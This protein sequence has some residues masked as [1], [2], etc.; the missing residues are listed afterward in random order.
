MTQ[1]EAR[2]I[3]GK[4]FIA[5][6][7]VA[8]ILSVSI[9]RKARYALQHIPYSDGTLQTCKKSHILFP[10]VPEDNSG[11]LITIASIRE[12]FGV[13]F[14][15][16]PCFSYVDYWYIDENFASKKT[17]SLR[18]Y[19]I[20]KSILP[21]SRTKSYHEQIRLLRGDE[22]LPSAVEIVYMTFLYYFVSDG[23]RLFESSEVLCKDA[24]W[25]GRIVTAG[26]FNNV[27]LVISQVKLNDRSKDLG[28]APVLRNDF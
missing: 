11:N 15:E 5:I 25:D 17:C 3:M 7:D 2:E 13:D 10:G 20:R 1:R 27:G 8:R 14:D 24:G 22:E 4:N 9:S 12:T 23:K 21:N 6:D 26:S 18:W 19:L 28:L 16:Q